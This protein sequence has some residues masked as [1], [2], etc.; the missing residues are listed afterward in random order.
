MCILQYFRVELTPFLQIS[1][2]N[3]SYFNYL[4]LKKRY[5]LIYLVKFIF[6]CTIFRKLYL[7][8][9]NI[10]IKKYQIVPINVWAYIIINI[11]IYRRLFETQILIKQVHRMFF[12]NFDNLKS[13]QKLA[14]VRMKILNNIWENVPKTQMLYK[15]IKKKLLFW[16]R[17]CTAHFCIFTI[18]T[19]KFYRL[20]FLF[21]CEVLLTIFT[22]ALLS[23]PVL[24]ICVLLFTYIFLQRCIRLQLIFL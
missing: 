11:N 8:Y 20:M 6:K 7:A 22:S 16:L 10:K 13:V 4:I 12:F 21:Q 24:R 9:I 2:S 18:L 17:Y 19:Q 23:I 5:L 1:D 14:N 3:N 15:R